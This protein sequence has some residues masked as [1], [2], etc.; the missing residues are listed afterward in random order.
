MLAQ[1]Q[2]C[3]V[4]FTNRCGSTYLTEIM[5]EAGFPVPPRVEVFNRDDMALVCREHD[6]R[7]IT[8]YFLQIV[9]GWVHDGQ[10][11][12]KIGAR[13]LSG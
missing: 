2:I 4:A 5:H 1:V 7:T 11:G 6:I 3:L 8:D 10:V 13:Q 9:E 12:F